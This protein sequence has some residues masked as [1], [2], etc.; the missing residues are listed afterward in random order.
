MSASARS[1]LPRSARVSIVVPI[2]NEEAYIERTLRALLAQDYPRDA[3][4]ILVVDGESDDRTCE[5]VSRIAAEDSRIR[6]LHNASRWSSAGR[7]IGVE[8]AYG[9]I[10][11]IV[12]GHCELEGTKHLLHL[13]DA[14]RVS[15]ADVIGRPQPL[16]IG[17]P[18]RLQMVIALARASWLGHHPDSYIYSLKDCFVPAESVGAAYRRD[19]FDRIGVFDESFDACEDVDFNYRADQAG[20][21][22][23]LSRRAAVGYVPRGSIAG[24][25]HQLARYGR[26]RVRL[27]RKHPETFSWKSFGPAFFVAFLVIGLIVSCFDPRIAIA[28]AAVV[29]SYLVV[30]VAESF[31]ICVRNRDWKALPWL[32]LVFAAIHLGAGVGSLSEMIAGGLFPRVTQP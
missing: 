13:V 28:Y 9:D 23:F 22:C 26:G 24:L 18:S 6:L 11:L 8:N 25:F 3:M 27:W 16:T 32:P 7:N 17:E 19:V 12:D 2:R 4:E 10:V 29:S 15:G 21:K 1:V 31:R 30:V 5:I 20:M 14:F